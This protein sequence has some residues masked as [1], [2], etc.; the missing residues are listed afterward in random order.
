[1]DVGA[2]G[3]QIAVPQRQLAGV[4]VCRHPVV[5]VD[6]RG[7]QE[8]TPHRNG[9]ADENVA[10]VARQG[11]GGRC[12]RMAEWICGIPQRRAERPSLTPYPR[13]SFANPSSQVAASSVLRELAV[14][15]SALSL[16]LWRYARRATK[17]PVA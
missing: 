6:G 14:C 12:D 7:E 1:M 17:G 9:R 3:Q 8:V 11:S 2:I 4:L 5:L 15:T 10:A 13:W 16:F